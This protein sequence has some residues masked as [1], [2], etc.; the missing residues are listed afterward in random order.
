MKIIPFTTNNVYPLVNSLINNQVA[1]IPTDTIYGLHLPVS[2]ENLVILNSLK[3]R[4]LDQPINVIYANLGQ[5]KP[6]VVDRQ[7]YKIF[8]LIHEIP[9]LS[10]IV[11]SNLSLSGYSQ[12]FRL[13]TRENDVLRET[14]ELV[15]PLLSTSANL[16]KRPYHDDIKVIHETFSDITAVYSETAVTKS[17]QSPST[18]VDIRDNQLRLIR[19]GKTPFNIIQGKYNLFHE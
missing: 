18:I 19:P 11:T 14:L 15:G 5:I 2:R 9:Y 13:I 4:A 3:Q 7:Q 17:D 6:F 1:I 10:V 8:E 12:S 16:H